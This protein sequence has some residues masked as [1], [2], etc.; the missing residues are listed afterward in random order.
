MAL[1]LLLAALCLS[2][3][4]LQDGTNFN[5]DV[6]KTLPISVRGLNHAEI[7]PEWEGE[8]LIFLDAAQKEL[9]WVAHYSR[10]TEL[11]T[12]VAID[13]LDEDSQFIDISILDV[14]ENAASILAMTDDRE[15]YVYL[16][17]ANG[18]FTKRVL[19]NYKGQPKVN[20]FS[21]YSSVHVADINNDGHS[22]VIYGATFI[23]ASGPSFY[24]AL[25]VF[26]YDQETKWFTEN[27]LLLV[28]DVFSNWETINGVTF[29]DNHIYFSGHD[30]ATSNKGYVKR[31]GVTEGAFDREPT[32]VLSGVSS[33]LTSLTYGDLDSDGDND[34][35]ACPATGFSGNCI[36]ATQVNSAFTATEINLDANRVMIFD[37]DLDDN[38]NLDLFLASNEKLFWY[39]ND[40]SGQNIVNG[41]N[42]Y[43]IHNFDNGYMAMDIYQTSGGKEPDIVLAMGS[44]T[45]E[46]SDMIKVLRN[47]VNVI[48]EAACNASGS[49]TATE[50][51]IW[52]AVGTILG[53]VG[54][55]VVG[56][57]AV[58]AVVAI[59]G[60][61]RVKDDMHELVDHGD[62]Y[63]ATND[64]EARNSDDLM[65]IKGDHVKVLARI[66]S[67]KWVGE[68]E[69]TVGNVDPNY[70]K[71]L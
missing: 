35:A 12:P 58:Y 27:N 37:L 66:N 63:V 18:T 51:A 45:G 15:L 5:I 59:R 61:K 17:H 22:D 49:F 30:Y 54:G 16:N 48:R 28:T 50:T 2:A 38:G 6:S 71:Q 65:F 60:P 3:F 41:D 31:W 40:G 14:G 47:D 55:I 70:L 4:A 46:S 62:M 26:V 44:D 43:E 13:N 23:D 52:V 64:H 33:A 25:H 10:W 19:Q 67:K 36:V 8:E 53:L 1:A 34:I 69:G 7:Y 56:A 57:L 42:F 29:F 21:K 20:W 9:S 24:N 32:L 68:C 39:R 11:P